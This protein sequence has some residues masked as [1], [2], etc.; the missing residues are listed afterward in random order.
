[1]KGSVEVDGMSGTS[2]TLAGCLAASLWTVSSVSGAKP[3]LVRTRAALESSPH[4]TRFDAALLIWSLDL[5]LATLAAVLPL[6][7]KVFHS[8][9]LNCSYTDCTK[10]SFPFPHLARGRNTIRGMSISNFQPASSMGLLLIFLKATK[11]QSRNLALTAGLI[12][13]TDLGGTELKISS[14]DKAG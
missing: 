12:I 1:M 11:Q 2:H 9:L 13:C 5:D 14:G 6:D 3:E 10:D 8:N 4:L 7:N